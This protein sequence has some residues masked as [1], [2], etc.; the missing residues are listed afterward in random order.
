MF[1]EC[2]QKGLELAHGTWFCL[3]AQRWLG[4]QGRHRFPPRDRQT[5]AVAQARVPN[6]TRGGSGARRGAEDRARRNRRRELEHATRRLPRRVAHRSG[7][8]AAAVE[9]PQL[10]DGWQA[11]EASPR[12]VQAPGAH[13]A[14]D[15]EVLCRTPRPR[16]AQREGPVAEDGQEHTRR[17]AQGTRRRGTAWPRSSERS[18]GSPRANRPAARDVDV[19]VRSA[20]DVLRGRHGVEDAQRIHDPRNDRDAPR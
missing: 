2:A 7:G 14:A 13:P 10:R 1:T 8:P 18:S 6:Q 12:Q 16:S 3:Q 5:P 4:V 19:V 15:R 11:T 17:V 20:Q 9:P